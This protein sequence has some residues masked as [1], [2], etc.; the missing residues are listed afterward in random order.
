MIEA[1]R[2]AAAR[3]LGSGGGSAKALRIKGGRALSGLVGPLN[4][5]NILRGTGGRRE[6]KL[7]AP[8]WGSNYL[9][10]RRLVHALR[11]GTTRAPAKGM[12]DPVVSGPFRKNNL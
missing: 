4:L 10:S 7:R 3:R 1:G 5:K 11:V 12:S 6:K 2:R 8:V 9:G